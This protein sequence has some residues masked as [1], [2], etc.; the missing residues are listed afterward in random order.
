MA[1][2]S[3]GGAD[4]LDLFDSSRCEVRP[5]KEQ[6]EFV[7]LTH[8]DAGVQAVPTV[9][10]IEVQAT[11]G[12]PKPMTTQTEP[13]LMD[14]AKAHAERRRARHVLKRIQDDLEDAPGEL[15]V[16]CL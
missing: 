16:Q 5:K 1:G 3:T 7:T 13:G 11:P 8:L 14:P 2:R 6:L 15:C 4:A 12:P 9:S 10:E